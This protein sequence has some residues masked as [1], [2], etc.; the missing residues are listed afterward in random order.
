MFISSHPYFAFMIGLSF[1][2]SYVYMAHLIFLKKYVGIIHRILSS[3]IL[4]AQ[5]GCCGKNI[6]SQMHCGTVGWGHTHSKIFLNNEGFPSPYFQF[7]SFYMYVIFITSSR[8]WIRKWLNR[9]RRIS[10]LVIPKTNK[11]QS[12]P[13]GSSFHCCNC[14]LNFWMREHFNTIIL[15]LIDRG[16]PPQQIC[17]V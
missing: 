9:E 15:S 14:F 13:A 16:M 8:R 1:L 2:N 5:D 17:W 3:I 11:S 7:S 10:S 4:S 6:S 12:T